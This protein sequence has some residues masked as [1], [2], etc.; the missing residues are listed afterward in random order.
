M[1]ENML[2]LEE[3]SKLLISGI[4]SIAKTHKRQS[5]RFRHIGLGT[6]GPEREYYLASARE[7]NI[8]Y[9]TALTILK[10]TTEYYRRIYQ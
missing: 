1:V 9:E 6:I 8:A 7:S 4:A 10:M 5:K 2:S 3:E